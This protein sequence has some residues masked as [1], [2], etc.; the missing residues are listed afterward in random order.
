MCKF[1]KVLR[2]EKKMEMFYIC[3]YTDGLVWGCWKRGRPWRAMVEKC[4]VL[5][6][7]SG[8][9]F[10]QLYQRVGI[11]LL[12]KWFDKEWFW[13]EKEEFGEINKWWFSGE[14]VYKRDFL[15]SS[16]EIYFWEK[17]LNETSYKNR[18]MGKVLKAFF[19]FFNKDMEI[20]KQSFIKQKYILLF[21]TRI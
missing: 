12:E 11:R 18:F 10:M 19:L 16:T 5:C 3:N 2:F 9:C 20:S 15:P 6:F 13:S 7:E 17:V 14:N 1:C 21:S 4:R 8:K